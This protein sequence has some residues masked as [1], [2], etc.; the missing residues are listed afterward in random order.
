MKLNGGQDA[1][2]GAMGGDLAGVAG[3]ATSTTATSL[4][5]T[6]ASFG[7]LTGHMVAAG[8]S[9]GVVTSNTGTVLTFDR[10]YAPASPGGAAGTTPGG[11]ATYVVLPGQAPY[12]YL[13]ITSN[14]TAPAATD[15]TLASEYSTASGGLLRKLATY[16]HTT[17][18]A[19]YSLATTF[20]ANA[21]DVPNLPF[22]AAKAG[23]FNTLTNT[24][25]RMQFETAISPTAVL[26][27]S[28]D[29]LTLTDTVS[30]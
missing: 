25:G 21:S 13:A 27:A 1:Q 29:Q 14:S 20:T 3:T 11:T 24:T 7:T 2:A 10:W 19:S 4:T 16:A 15:T 22:T 18:V 8:V 5:D 28:G 12:W 6:G 30:L 17:G 26:S 23:V 9:Y